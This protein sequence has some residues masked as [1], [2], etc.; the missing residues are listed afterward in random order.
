MFKKGTSDINS[1]NT[2][3]IK[4][5]IDIPVSKQEL[6]NKHFGHCRFIYNWAID[7][8]KERYK[9]NETSFNY[10][11]L[12]KLLPQLKEENLFLKQVDSTCLQQSL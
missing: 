4:C 3:N 11:N 10:V 9:N 1:M 2:V 12:A 7:Y 6:L 8:N 5:N